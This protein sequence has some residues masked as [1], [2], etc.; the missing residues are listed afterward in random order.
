[1]PKTIKLSWQPGVG[2]RE[3][4][5]KKFYRGKAYY[6]SGGNGKSDREGY[7]AAWA[8]WETL[9]AQIDLTAP[10]KHQQDYEAAIDQWEQVLA[11]SNR[12]GDKEHADQATVKLVDL[13]RRF[14]MR[15][16]VVPGP[17]GLVRGEL[18]PANTRRGEGVDSSTAVGAEPSRGHAT[19][20]RPVAA[21]RDVAVAYGLELPAE[22]VSHHSHPGGNR[23]S[24]RQPATDRT[25]ALAG[26]AGGYEAE[27]RPRGRE[28]PGPHPEV[29]EA[30]GEPGEGERGQHR[31]VLRPEAAPDAL[32]GLAWQGHVRQGDRR[33][34]PGEL[35]YA[36]SGEGDLEGMDQDD[37]QPLHDHGQVVRPLA[38]AEQRDT[39]V[40]QNLGR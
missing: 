20:G 3:G 22:P 1:M 25:R 17:Q 38:L 24:G 2:N 34:G 30:K 11:W 27:G 21:L 7:D 6:F 32:P 26:P 19:I 12:Y 16:A 37:V 33:R 36:R 18:R 28:P 5:W 13:R 4:R 29:P 39:Y 31:A 15:Q 9:K 35:P 23:L 40:A 10:R 14:A 8:A